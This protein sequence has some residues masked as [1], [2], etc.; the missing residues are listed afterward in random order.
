M[1]LRRHVSLIDHSH[2]SAGQ[3][4]CRII[5][6]ERTKNRGISKEDQEI[7]TGENRT[8]SRVNCQMYDIDRTLIDRIS[9]CAAYPRGCIIY[10]SQGRALAAGGRDGNRNPPPLIEKVHQDA[11]KLLVLDQKCVVPVH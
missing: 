3:E 6:R 7:S 9:G 4:R 1:S 10:N 2:C 8:I 11:A 5:A